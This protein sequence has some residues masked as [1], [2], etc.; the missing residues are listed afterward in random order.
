MDK[1][2]RGIKAAQE[3]WNPTI[4]KA[5][6]M[7]ILNLGN[8]IFECAV[9]E[10]GR[11]ILTK[12]DVY[13]ALGRARPSSA[14]LKRS[15]E[16]N[17]PVFMISNNLTPYLE[18]EKTC[19]IN[20]VEFRHLSGKKLKGF[21]A[22]ILP[23]ACKL[24]VK[25]DDDGALQD[26]QK[27][28]AKA[29]RI[30][31]YGL[32][33]IGIISLVDDATGYV[34]QRN[35]NELQKILDKYISEELR[36]WTKKFPDEFFKQVYRIHDWNY[37]K[38][39]NHPQYLGKFITKYVYDKLPEGVRYELENKNPKNENGCRKYRHHQ[40]LT[41]DVGDDNLKKQLVQT[42]TIMKL[43]SNIEEFKELVERLHG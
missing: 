22:R 38:I 31:L 26:Q 32:A 10:D 41:E 3:R 36:E 11:R 33:T 18:K 7:G 4:P 14:A 37:P 29:C 17:L 43:S 8:K 23:E 40:F 1:H 6:H 5:T 30:I 9:L 2:E 20:Q 12:S 25:A 13:K 27:N 16:L 39:G 19:A 24:Y 35:R 15:E 42:I 34:D 21:D 28:I